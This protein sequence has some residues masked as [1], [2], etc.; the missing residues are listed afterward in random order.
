MALYWRWL[1]IEGIKSTCKVFYFIWFPFSD[2]TLHDG[3]SSQIQNNTGTTLPIVFLKFM[4]QTSLQKRQWASHSVS[5][6]FVNIFITGSQTFSP[7]PCNFQLSTIVG[8]T[9]S[10]IWLN[11][12][13][14]ATNK[15]LF[16][17]NPTSQFCEYHG[18]MHVKIPK[19]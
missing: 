11:F 18:I 15:I 12:G 13:Y 1:Y 9:K 17:D 16:N 3:C 7:K 5:D 4:W 10:S 19:V 14:P 6:I 2:P 8:M